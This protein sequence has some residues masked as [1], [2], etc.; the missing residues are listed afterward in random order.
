VDEAKIQ[1]VMTRMGLK[2]K[3]G[4]SGDPAKLARSLA[5]SS[6]FVAL[7]LSLC[8]PVGD[9]FD[10]RNQEAR[11]STL[12][13][14]SNAVPVGSSLISFTEGALL[15]ADIKSFCLDSKYK[16]CIFKVLA[17]FGGAAH[18]AWV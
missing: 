8:Y 18:E 6:H 14:S 2:G 4:E 5:R 17:F 11:H 9:S 1:Q 16:Y 13:I 7:L 3:S 12:G 15:L 10:W